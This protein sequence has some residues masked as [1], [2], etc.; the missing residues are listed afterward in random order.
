MLLTAACVCGIGVVLA[1]SL[2]PGGLGF[3]LRPPVLVHFLAYFV[4]GL[5]LALVS[6]GRWKVLLGVVI[7]L[8]L[9]GFVVELLQTRIPP[10][11][12]LW[13]DAA[14]NAAGAL[15]GVLLAVFLSILAR[16]R[17]RRSHGFPTTGRSS[18][19]K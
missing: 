11:S 5:G 19:R 18:G 12:F 16:V 8:S 1:G 7:G 2:L 17:R 4:L 6:G 3:G 14:A 9:L 10:R 15:T 13:A